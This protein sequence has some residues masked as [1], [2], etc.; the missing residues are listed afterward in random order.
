M[1]RV[2]R[3]SSRFLER[4]F[5]PRATT[6]PLVGTAIVDARVQGCHVVGHVGTTSSLVPRVNGSG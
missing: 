3:A 5:S 2:E 6:P 4:A 1:R